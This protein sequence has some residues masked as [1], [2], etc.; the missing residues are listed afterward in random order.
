MSIISKPP[1]HEQAAFKPTKN[2]LDTNKMCLTRQCPF[3]VSTYVH[4][5]YSCTVMCYIFIIG[6]MYVVNIHV[7]VLIL[8]LRSNNGKTRTEYATVKGL[9]G[10]HREADASKKNPTYLNI[11]HVCIV[12]WYVYHFLW[13]DSKIHV[14]MIKMS[15]NLVKLRM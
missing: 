8:L 1:A 3:Y 4:T 5:Y 15:V 14:G 11:R 13:N 6:Q 12:N 10:P 7:Y 2:R 9:N